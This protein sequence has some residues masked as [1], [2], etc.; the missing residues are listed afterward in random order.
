MQ[1]EVGCCSQ[2]QLCLRVF[3]AEATLLLCLCSDV[4]CTSVDKEAEYKCSDVRYTRRGA[5]LDVLDSA[6]SAVPPLLELPP[7]VWS[8]SC[9][10]LSK[11]FDKVSKD[12]SLGRRTSGNALR[13]QPASP[14]LAFVDRPGSSPRS[15]EAMKALNY[16]FDRVTGLA[17]FLGH[18][19][20]E[21]DVGKNARKKSIVDASARGFFLMKPTDVQPMSY[22][23]YE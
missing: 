21:D 9:H 18:T 4:R 11:S 10:V 8:T 7:Q 20:T 12:Q 16:N 2:W 13:T 19:S 23:Y 6:A 22:L 3:C 17:V 1:F 5:L 15:P 14:L